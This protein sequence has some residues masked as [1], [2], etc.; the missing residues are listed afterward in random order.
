MEVICLGCITLQ[1]CKLPGCI[2]YTS[3]EPCP[4]CMATCYWAGLE[5]AFY[6]SASEDACRYGSFDDRP[7]FEQLCLPKEQRSIKVTQLLRDETV[8][9]WKEYQAKPDKV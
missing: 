3:A 1:S 7:I 4:M 6:A 9:V 8:A 5:Q 2:P